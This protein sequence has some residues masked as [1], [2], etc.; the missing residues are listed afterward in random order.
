MRSGRARTVAQLRQRGYNLVALM[1]FVTVLNVFAAAGLEAWSHMMRRQREEELIFRGLQYAEAIR[2]FQQRFGRYPSRL[3][4]LV[5]VEPRSI[6]Q[7]WTDPFNEDGGWQL[8]LAQQQRPRRNTDRSNR[9]RR[10]NR[11][12]R[13]TEELDLNQPQQLTPAGGEELSGATGPDGQRVGPIFG[14]K[15]K[16]PE[17]S[18]RSFFGKTTY[19]EWE[20]TADT[21]KVSGATMLGDAP[22]RLTS[23]WVGRP[24]REGVNPLRVP[25]GSGKQALEGALLNIGTPSEGTPEN[26]VRNPGSNPLNN[27]GAARDQ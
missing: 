27:P 23:E 20:F 26:P 7:L 25:L 21:V 9:G 22:A 14:V 5:E 6:R 18:L 11:Q 12:Q 8:I 1:V 17:T 19:S 13:R 16:V 15:S 4:E 10:N 2:V 24:F 3:E